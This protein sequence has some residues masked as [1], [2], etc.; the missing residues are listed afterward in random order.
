M[1]ALDEG[2]RLMLAFRDGDDAAF[3]ALFGRW[4]APLLRYL[5]RMVSDSAT[6]E[7]LV[8]EAFLRVHGARDRYAPDARFSTWLYRI[9]T[10]LALN[11]LR[12][13]RR[14]ARHESTHDAQGAPVDL[15]A[16]QPDV[17]AVVD[18]R[19]AG[20]AL[21]AELD[22]LPERQRVAL[23]LTAVEGQSYAEV[24]ETLDATEKSVKALV[25]RARST[26]AE[27][28]TSAGERREPV[29]EART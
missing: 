13:P 2:A 24:A 5:E 27:R 9:A 23:W 29:R 16:E 7:E 21:E 12:R 17:D 10:N 25:H 11:E 6:A 22:A 8:Q 20:D 4:A 19:R 15:R 26:L 1:N 28:M 3:D 14:K 18:A